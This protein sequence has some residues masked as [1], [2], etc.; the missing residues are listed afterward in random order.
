MTHHFASSP[1]KNIGELQF[2]INEGRLTVKSKQNGVVS[3]GRFFD[4]RTAI[5]IRK[6][7]HVYKC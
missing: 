7:E 5:K 4:R 2:E 3:Y 1:P 6:Y